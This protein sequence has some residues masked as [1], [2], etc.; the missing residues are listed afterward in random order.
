MI[1]VDKALERLQTE[2]KPIKVGMVGAGFMAKGIA[3]Q[4]VKYVPGI[5]LSVICNRNPDNARQ[6]YIEANVA[7]EDVTHVESVTALNTA[8][9]NKKYAVTE[10]PDLLCE[11]SAIDVLVEVTGTIE[12]G[13]R[14]VLNATGRH[15][16]QC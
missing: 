12:E 1:I 15:Y 11:S 5:N 2:G 10:N 3:L 9:E 4:L 14:V 6:A 13:A 7:P 16:Y 8:I